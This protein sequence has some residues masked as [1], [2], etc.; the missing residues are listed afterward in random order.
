MKEEKLISVTVLMEAMANALS[1]V[2][3]DDT[4]NRVI[5]ALE[6]SIEYTRNRYQQLVF[7]KGREKD[8]CVHLDKIAWLEADGSYTKFH[9]IGGKTQILT[10]NLAST[11]R[12]LESHGYYN[13][14][15]IHSSHAVNTDH[16]TARCGT[17]FILTK[18]ICL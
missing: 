14:L 10:A 5:E 16:V 11:L 8:E 4:K 6:N 12:Q 2:G 7:L 15:R 18:K 13:F 3:D 17:H 1:K 9:S